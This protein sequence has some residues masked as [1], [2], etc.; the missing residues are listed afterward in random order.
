MLTAL[1]LDQGYFP[2]VDIAFP[3]RPQSLRIASVG[4]SSDTCGVYQGRVQTLP[5]L[6][7]TLSDEGS[8][9]AAEVTFGVQ[10][11]DNTLG[12]L[13]EGPY[14]S[15]VYGSPVRI[16]LASPAVL[17]SRWR[18]LFRGIIVKPINYESEFAATITARVDDRDLQR[19]APNSGWLGTKP[20]W[21][22]INPEHVGR[23][24]P[25]VWGTKDSQNLGAKGSVELI[26]VDTLSHK[27]AAAGR[28][29]V[30]RVFD[31]GVGVSSSNW[32]I[33]Y[34]ERAGRL[35]T[36][37][38]FTTAKTGP[39]AIDCTGFDTTN[40]SG[41]TPTAD[42]AECIK[43]GLSNFILGDWK[44]GGGEPWLSTSPRIDLSRFADAASR[45]TRR[46]HQAGYALTE[47]KTGYEILREWLNTYQMKV[48]WTPQGLLGIVME[49]PADLMIY[50][51]SLNRVS[52]NELDFN[53]YW[54]DQRVTPG[55]LGRY[56]F[57]LGSS[58]STV[59]AVEPG[60]EAQGSDS[61]D[62]TWFAAV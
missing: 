57:I 61:I 36:I 35:W 11:D 51:P 34:E 5:P 31:N 22:N 58:Q 38:K 21:G 44:G 19:S 33:L 27:W 28:I 4:H 3:F 50:P 26:H 10:D 60:S 56:N 16:R 40:P 25:L 55:V 13:I 43:H 59:E 49:D 6:R 62:L 32:V 29:G 17:P 45:L 30:A 48:F 2:V 53:Y 7:E 54:D 18:D 41:G 1:L 24:A 46:G 47:Q 15:M 23:L 12:S 14:G 42:P 37:V 52:H 9:A 8:S 39:I 20:V